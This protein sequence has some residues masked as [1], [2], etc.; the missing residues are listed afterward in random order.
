M[1]PVRDRGYEVFAGNPNKEVGE[2]AHA[3]PDLRSIPGSVDAVVIGTRLDRA[4]DAVRECV[5]LG[6]NRVWIHR[7]SGAGSDSREAT[8]Y[9][10]DHGITVID[11]SCP[12]MFC[13][14]SDF[15][16]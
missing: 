7:R 6:T 8:E 4:Q 11:G 2:D 15:A 1:I 9:G 14:T 10:R 13:P 5:E 3:Y 16:R 12:L